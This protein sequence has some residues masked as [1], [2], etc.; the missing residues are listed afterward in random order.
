MSKLQTAS[1][2]SLNH[3]ISLTKGTH[4]VGIFKVHLGV[5]TSC[6]G[7]MKFNGLTKNHS[8]LCTKVAEDTHTHTHTQTQRLGLVLAKFITTHNDLVSFMQGK[9]WTH[10]L[11]LRHNPVTHTR[12]NIH[13]E[14]T[15]TRTHISN[16]TKW[17][18]DMH[19]QTL[20]SLPVSLLTAVY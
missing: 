18:T 17:H 10:T 5:F 14:N 16:K 20:L 4:C 8:E 13:Y 12:K 19:T 1:L 11:L 6:F 9:S 7:G 2:F 15:I 3:V